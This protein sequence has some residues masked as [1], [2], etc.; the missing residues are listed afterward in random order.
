MTTIGMHYDVVAG[1]E[2][3]FEKG[4]LDIIAFLKTFPGHVE[5][6][7]YEDVA[8]VGSYVILSRWES[9]EAFQRFMQS[10]EFAKVT[11]WGRTEMLRGRPQH[12]VYAEP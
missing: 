10:P 6:R 11:E 4:F 2:K 7:M 3:E 12:K 5:S 8:A 1:R 9:R